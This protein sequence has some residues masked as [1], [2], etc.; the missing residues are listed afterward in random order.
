MRIFRPFR[1]ATRLDLLAVPAAHL[2]A[3]VAAGEADHVVLGVEL[4]HQLEAV[5]FVRPGA[6]LAAVQAEGN[7]AAEGEVSSLP[8]K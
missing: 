1:S 3:G 7:G 4:A 6:H 2:G 5:A 8:K